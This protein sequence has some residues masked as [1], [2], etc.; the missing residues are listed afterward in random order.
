MGCIHK[1]EINTSASWHEAGSAR[2][3]SW[4]LH[5][6]DAKI[7]ALDQAV[8]VVMALGLQFPDF[9]KADFPLSGWDD[10]LRSFADELENWRGFILRATCRLVATATKRLR[11]SITPSDFNLDSQTSRQN[12]NG[13]LLGVV[14]NVGDPN[15]KNPRVYQTNKYLPYNTDPSDVVGLLCVRKAKQGGKSSLVSIATLYNRLR[16]DHPEYLGVLH[17]PLHYA[18]LDGDLPTLS[19]LLNFH[20]RK[21]ACRYLRQYIELGDEGAANSSGNRGA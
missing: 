12:L 17:R 13:D 18:Q 19:L 9:G 2:D 21:L 4:F 1:Q 11:L 6:T 3:Q 14:M 20:N 16:R 8:V 10:W 7:A 5:F 15:D